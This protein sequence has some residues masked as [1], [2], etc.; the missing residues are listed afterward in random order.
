MLAIKGHMV[1]RYDPKIQY[2]HLLYK[3]SPLI[4]SDISKKSEKRDESVIIICTLMSYLHKMMFQNAEKDI[5]KII[6]IW[7]NNKNIHTAKGELL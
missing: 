3:I 5:G 6:Y 4:S 2:T 7:Y 1:F